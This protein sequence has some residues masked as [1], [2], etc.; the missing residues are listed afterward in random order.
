[1]SSVAASMAVRPP[2]ITTAG[3]LTWRFASASSLNA[4]VSC[5]AM[6]KSDAL[7][8]PRR[9]LFFSPMIVGRPAPA[10]SATWRKPRAHASSTVMVPP[11]RVPA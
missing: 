3:N 8:M 9:R 7:R 1:M 2:P 6:R 4:P 5:S 11:K 10:A